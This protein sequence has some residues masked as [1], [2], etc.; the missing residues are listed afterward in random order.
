MGRRE[1]TPIVPSQGPV[2]VGIILRAWRRRQGLSVTEVA[3]QV[4]EEPT[5]LSHIE[6]GRN[7]PAPELLAKLA[8]VYATTVDEIL[9]TPRERVREWL[10]EGEEIRR[11][12]L[13]AKRAQRQRRLPP[14]P[15]VPQHLGQPLAHNIGLALGAPAPPS[16]QREE[17]TASG[18]MPDANDDPTHLT[19][20]EAAR[21]TVA[22]RIENLLTAAQLPP[23]KEE[24]LIEE[25]IDLLARLLRLMRT[26]SSV[27]P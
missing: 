9:D 15:A 14:V 4:D 5:Y 18:T 25:F 1:K 3:V 6:N 24:A 16:R 22:E 17:Q 8:D 20:P 26:G 11:Q 21:R 27:P 19:R 12:L 23:E 7:R 2:P 10:I 13:R